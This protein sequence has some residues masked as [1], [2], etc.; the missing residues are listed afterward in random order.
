MLAQGHSRW[1]GTERDTWTQRRHGNDYIMSQKL[2]CPQIQSRHTTLSL[3]NY[4]DVFDIKKNTYIILLCLKTTLFAPNGTAAFYFMQVHTFLSCQMDLGDD[5]C[6]Y[7]LLVVIETARH[8]GFAWKSLHAMCYMVDFSGWNVLVS[9]P[10]SQG[11]FGP[12]GVSGRAGKPGRDGEPGHDGTPGSRGLPGL[13][14]RGRQTAP[15][16][17]RYFSDLM[18]DVLCRQSDLKRITST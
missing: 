7:L 8:I 10:L 12:K 11:S 6:L 16:F 15:V 5:K 3:N 2:T 17:Y 18:L 13:K 9:V 4:L 14:V 1:A